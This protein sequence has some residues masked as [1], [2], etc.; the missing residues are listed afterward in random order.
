MI[1]IILRHETPN[2][3]E[4]PLSNQNIR[5]RFYGIND[6]VA[7]K[8]M[9]RYQ[10][11]VKEE[12]IKTGN[13]ISS[14]DAQEETTELP[15]TTPGLPP[16]LPMPSTEFK[17]DFFN[18]SSSSSFSAVIQSKPKPPQPKTNAPKSSKN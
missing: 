4:D 16:A 7:D 1:K 18:L 13:T 15:K 14:D 3:P 11:S 12:K 6:P 5:D 9:A 17:N 2:D 8:L 10:E